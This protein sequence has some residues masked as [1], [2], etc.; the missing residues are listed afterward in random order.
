MSRT[1]HLFLT[2][3]LVVAAAA[4]AGWAVY[5]TSVDRPVQAAL[6]RQDAMEWLRTD[7]NLTDAQFAAI[8]RLHDAYAIVC[9]EH[10][11]AI[12]DATHARATLKSAGNADAAALA[13][14]DR[15]VEELRTVCETAIAAHVRQC[16]SLMAPR[17]AERYLALV[18]PLIKDFDHVAP[19]DLKLS[20]PHAAH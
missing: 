4:G 3:A 6:A 13:A 8:K 18:L 16:A 7:F 15:R 9:E 17:D 1:R 11:R 2:L 5:R 20:R 19:P 10:C 14:A 12:Q